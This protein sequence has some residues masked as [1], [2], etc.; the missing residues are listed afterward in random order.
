MEPFG[1]DDWSQPDSASLADKWFVDRTHR[2]GVA[3][4]SVG[5]AWFGL[6]LVNSL[7][8]FCVQS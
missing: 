7:K 6:V 5:C 3:L 8:R 2:R 4:L 1:R